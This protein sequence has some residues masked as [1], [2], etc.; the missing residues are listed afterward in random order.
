MRASTALLLDGGRA[1]PVGG[2]GVSLLFPVREGQDG[3]QARGGSGEGRGQTE[4]WRPV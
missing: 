2:R 1:V 4:G 3:A